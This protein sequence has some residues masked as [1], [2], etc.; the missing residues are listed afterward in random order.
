MFRSFFGFVRR[1][2][3]FCCCCKKLIFTP[4][5]RLVAVVLI[6]DQFHSRNCKTHFPHQSGHFFFLSLPSFFPATVWWILVYGGNQNVFCIL[7]Y[8]P[9]PHS[10]SYSSPPRLIIFAVFKEPWAVV[11]IAPF[12]CSA[13]IIMRQVTI[14]QYSDDVHS[15]ISV[16]FDT[17]YKTVVTLVYAKFCPNAL[18]MFNTGNSNSSMSYIPSD[19]G[20]SWL[21][22]I[23]YH[24]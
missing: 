12:W 1:F 18:Y 6:Q 4:F 8:K 17:S 10:L 20:R 16:T 9:R 11:I 22:T 19:R 5:L 13:R 21:S 14:F 23:S 3:H 7:S 24:L 2:S 15:F